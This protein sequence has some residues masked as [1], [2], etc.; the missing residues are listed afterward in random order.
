MSVV[1]EI[2]RKR[3]I[4][5]MY[6]SPINFT[7]VVSFRTSLPNSRGSSFEIVNDEEIKMSRIDTMN[8]L[9]LQKIKYLEG[10]P[11]RSEV[12]GIKISVASIPAISCPVSI[13][14]MIRFDCLK[15]KRRPNKPQ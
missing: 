8:M 3:D 6:L 10:S 4:R 13:H 12:N 9:A 11:T 1:I 7:K 14:P 2:S 15:L 5:R